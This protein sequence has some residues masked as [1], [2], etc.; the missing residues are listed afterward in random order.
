M[1]RFWLS[2]GFRPKIL[3]TFSIF[4][5]VFKFHS[6]RFSDFGSIGVWWVGHLCDDRMP[7]CWRNLRTILVNGFTRSYFRWLHFQPRSRHWQRDPLP[8]ELLTNKSIAIDSMASKLFEKNYFGSNYS[9]SSFQSS[10]L[11]VLL[12]D[13]L[14]FNAKFFTR[15]WVSDPY[16]SALNEKIFRLKLG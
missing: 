2:T 3:T 4:M 15:V 10:F 1:L 12:L 14:L 7:S 9:K 8:M 5:N 11:K 13:L 6:K 16:S